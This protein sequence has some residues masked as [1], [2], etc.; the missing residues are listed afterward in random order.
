MKWPCILMDSIIKR[1]KIIKITKREMTMKV[2]IT[3]INR[4]KL[5]MPS[6]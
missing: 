4:S 2:N 1:K 5:K 6:T 3:D